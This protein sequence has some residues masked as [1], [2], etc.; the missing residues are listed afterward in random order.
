M[1]I[2][3]VGV[4]NTRFTA[5]TGEVISGQTIYFE[6]EDLHTRGLQTDKAFLPDS[7]RLTPE[8]SVP[9]SGSIFYNKYGKVESVILDK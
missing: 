8:P 4:K 2:I 5:Q 1:K 9:C 7:R 3:L 6:F